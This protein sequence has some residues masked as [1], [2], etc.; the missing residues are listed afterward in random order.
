MSSPSN[1]VVV[2]MS[3]QLNLV[4][5]H[6]WQLY[7]IEGICERVNNRTV[8]QILAEYALMDEPT[9]IASGQIPS[10]IFPLWP[11][12]SKMPGSTTPTC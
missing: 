4:K 3:R 1:D 5:M 12:P 7:D 11:T 10:T 6:Y 2:A 8:S 9:R